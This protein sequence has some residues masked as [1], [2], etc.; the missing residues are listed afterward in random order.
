MSGSVVIA[1]VIDRRGFSGF[2]F[3]VVLLC[4]MVVLLEGFDAQAMGYVAP[5]ITAALHVTRGALGPALGSAILGLLLG[6]LFHRAAGGPFRAQADH[7]LVDRGVRADLVVQPFAHSVSSLIV[8]PFPHRTWPRRRDGDA[9]S[10]TS[11]YT[12]R[13]INGLAIMVMFCGYSLGS[14]G[15]G[16]AAAQL[17]ARFGWP[18]IFVVGGVMPLLLTPY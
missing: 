13:R 16:F 1:D 4:A 7:H 2:Q 10:L 18:S 14:A 5:S 9:I 8:N 17:I 15:G 11:E 12:P 3:R 6:S